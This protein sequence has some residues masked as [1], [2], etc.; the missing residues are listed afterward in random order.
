[1][2]EMPDAW[3]TWSAETDDVEPD[4]AGPLAIPS[5]T[6]SP[7]SGRTNIV[8]FHDASTNVSAAKPAGASAKPTPTARAP[9]ILLASGV[10]NGVITII[11]AAAGRVARPAWSAFNP[12]VEGS[13]K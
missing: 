12:R 13:W 2:F 11:P 3:P 9:P 5:P 8:Y 6:A 4:D 1:M 7:T 10:M